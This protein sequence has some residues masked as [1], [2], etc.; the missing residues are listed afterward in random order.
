VAAVLHAPR[1]W[2]IRKARRLPFVIRLSRKKYICSRTA[3]RRWLASRLSY[4]RALGGS[5]RYRWYRQNSALAYGTARFSARNAYSAE[6]R[7]PGE[8]AAT[9]QLILK[10]IRH[11]AGQ[12]MQQHDSSG[13]PR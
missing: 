6:V 13:S 11:C 7:A 8:S 3:L 9:A 10:R 5:A 1:R 2:I 12:R 4:T